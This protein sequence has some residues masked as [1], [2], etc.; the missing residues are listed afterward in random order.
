[1]ATV[2]ENISSTATKPSPKRRGRQGLFCVWHGLNW[3][4]WNQLCQQAGPFPAQNR[5]RRLSIAAHS[6]LNSW[7]E[8]WEGC[9]YNR[10]LAQTQIEHPPLFI[11][12]H[13]RSGTTLLHNLLTL[14]PNLTYPNLYQVMFAGHFLLTEGLATRLTSWA[15]PKTRPMDNIPVG[16]RMSQEDEVALQLR[17][18]LSPYMMLAF[19]GQ[20]E[21]YVRYFELTDLTPDELAL[22]KS[23]F[24]RLLKKLTIREPKPIVR[25]TS[26]PI[27]PWENPASKTWR[28]TRSPPT[29]TASSATSRRNL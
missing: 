1:M 7:H 26:S 25:R 3:S 16:W 9:L 28:K 12:G 23:E 17:T 2:T 29:N 15:I 24:E 19:Q 8:F 22:W 5:M 13:W 21:K 4:G 10:R 11:L 6:L 18:L 20:R 27:T 14:D